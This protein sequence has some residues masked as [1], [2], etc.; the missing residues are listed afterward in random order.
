MDPLEIFP[1]PFR[2]TYYIAKA[3]YKCKDSSHAT[4][5]DHSE[6]YALVRRLILEIRETEIESSSYMKNN[7]LRMDILNEIKKMKTLK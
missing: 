3:V 2:W 1:V 5:Q 7:D 6:Y 4:K